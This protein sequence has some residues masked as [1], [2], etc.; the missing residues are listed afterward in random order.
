[1]N[2]DS[3]SVTAF[4]KTKIKKKG[5]KNLLIARYAICGVFKKKRAV[6]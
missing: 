6:Y 3:F 1:M 4:V 5:K 2:S